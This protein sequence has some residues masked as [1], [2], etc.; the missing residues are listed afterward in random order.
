MKKKF[1]FSLGKLEYQEHCKLIIIILSCLRQLRSI[2]DP[3]EAVLKAAESS[4]GSVEETQDGS[5]S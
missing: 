2:R 4:P 1:F 3:K 5:R